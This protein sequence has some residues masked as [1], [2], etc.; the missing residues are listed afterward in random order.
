MATATR[1]SVTALSLSQSALAPSLM[2]GRRR[3]L[4]ALCSGAWQEGESE[5]ALRDVVCF[6]SGSLDEVGSRLDRLNLAISPALVRRVVDSCSESSDSGRRLLRFLSWCRSK[7]PAGLGDEEHDRAIAVLA[8]MGD[9]T[10]M[11]IAVGDGEKDGRRMAPETFTTVVEA[12]VKAG[13]EDEAVRLFRGLERQKLLPQK[14]SGAGGEGI[15]CSSLAMV[16][17]LCMK[18]YAREAQ[19]VVWH[20]KSELSA[21]PMVSIVQRSLL[22]G[23]CVHGNAKEARRVLDDIKSSGCPLGLPSFNDFLNCVCHRNLK[24]NPSALVSEAMDILAEMR[25]YGVTPDSSSFNILLSCLGRARRVK[26]AYRILYLMREGEEGCSP[27][28]VSYYLVVKVLYL[29]DRIIRGKRLVE[30][31]LESGVLPTAKFFH[32]LIGILCGTE[33]VDHALDMFKIMK[34]CELVDTHTYDLLIEKLS[35]NGRFEV[36]KELWDDATKN[37][38]LLDC[39]EDLL[40]PLK[41]EVFRPF[42]FKRTLNFMDIS[43]EQQ[44]DFG[45]LLKQGAEG[46]VFVSTFVGRKCVIK[47]RFSKKY[48]HPLL[49]SK[50]TLK[51]LNAEA[52]CMTKARRLGVPTPVLYAV[53]PLPHTLTFEYV[54]GLC[55]KDI[56]IG[57]GSNGINEERLN[58][59]ATQ[60]GNAVGKLHDGGLVHGDL[61]TSNMMIKSSTNQL[62]LIDFGLSFTSTI[63]EDKAVDL[64][65]LER[66]LISMHSS[67]GDVMEKILAAYRKASRQWCATTNKLAQGTIP[68]HGPS[69]NQATG[70]KAN[71][72]R[73]KLDP[74]LLNATNLNLQHHPLC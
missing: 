56:L 38:I 30:D 66:A 69:A 67:C 13:K 53:D 46:R 12:L 36:A 52:R 4:R 54:D 3:I 34:S 26:E 11:K 65:V 25:S 17:T 61:T 50:L 42:C 32:G 14:V 58:D 51:R 6:G 43:Q 28:W 49:D 35:R 23:W 74:E 21:E 9:L 70:Q 27:D 16:Q 39:S 57:F 1:R 7:I 60:I 72:G 18:G 2:P 55:V 59:I 63:P 31:M 8:R 73:V 33:K 41:T 24:F 37:D 62:V 5:A 19:G 45:V 40:D 29:T 64:Y 22:H 68:G 71:N 20:H 15:W 10:A 48:R 44:Q 47:E